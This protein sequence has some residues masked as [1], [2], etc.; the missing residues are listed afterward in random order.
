[1]EIAEGMGDWEAKWIRLSGE[2]ENVLKARKLFG[3]G[4]VSYN[5]KNVIY[6]DRLST[7]SNEAKEMIKDE[8]SKILDELRNVKLPESLELIRSMIELG[9]K[10]IKGE[11]KADD[12]WSIIDAYAKLWLSERKPEGL[13]NVLSRFGKSMLMLKYN[14]KV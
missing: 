7:M 6:L 13:S 11:A 4:I 14:L 1:M 3:K 8:W 12:Y 9:L 10:V 2:D 5:I